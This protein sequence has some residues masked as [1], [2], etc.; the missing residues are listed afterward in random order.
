MEKSEFAKG[1]RQRAWASFK[2]YPGESVAACFVFLLIGG[3]ISALALIDMF[4]LMLGIVLLG[5][6]TVYSLFLFLFEAKGKNGKRRGAL[7]GFLSYFTRDMGVYR[8]I[9]TTLKTAGAFFVVY[10]T[11]ALIYV[12]IRQTNEPAVLEEMQRFVEIAYSEEG[13]SAA[14]FLV[15]SKYIYP[16]MNFSAGIA[17]GVAV[18]FMMQ[19]IGFY[20]LKVIMYRDSGYRSNRAMSNIFVVTVRRNQKYLLGLFFK[21]FWMIDLVYAIG[22][23]LGFGLGSIYWYGEMIPIALGFGGAVLFVAPLFAYYCHGTQW[24]FRLV[25][26]EFAANSIYLAERQ[27]EALKGSMQI[28]ED[29]YQQMM[30]QL[31]KMKKFNLD[32]E[33][34]FSEDP[35]QEQPHPEDEARENP[36]EPEE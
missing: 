34:R 8:A 4:V 15:S 25:E 29:Q 23:G 31:E 33:S 21:S 17:Q 2:E 10:I 35:F 36:E 7:Y 20:G 1:I 11:F 3:A 24:M 19:I 6:P 13:G 14:N 9:L 12:Y 32:M 22:F 16:M 30:Q 5:F 28:P 27:I 18:F 26:K